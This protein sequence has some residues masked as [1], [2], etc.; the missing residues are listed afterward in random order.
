MKRAFALFFLSALFFSRLSLAEDTNW[1][2]EDNCD[3]ATDSLKTLKSVT[4]DQCQQG[5]AADK[6][7]AGF[8]YITGW[9]R[10]LLKDQMKKTARLRFIS[11]ELD[12]KRNFDKSSLKFDFDHNGKD[13]E[14]KVFDQP[15]MCAQACT[16]RADCHAFTFLEGYRVCWLKAGGGHLN[17]KIFRCGTK[18]D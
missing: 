4:Q 3:V 5:C 10:C 15:E 8:V 13:L 17:E 16:Q 6:Q 2:L 18:K 14:R 11:G 7:C 12:D 9:K 1:K